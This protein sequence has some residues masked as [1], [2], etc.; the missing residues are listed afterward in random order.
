MILK[1]LLLLSLEDIIAAILTEANWIDTS[2]KESRD[3]KTSRV[4]VSQ[5]LYQI[6]RKVGGNY[7]WT[8]WWKCLN[9]FVI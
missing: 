4:G 3:N 2:C 7:V 1:K 6:I 5:V 8:S 9:V